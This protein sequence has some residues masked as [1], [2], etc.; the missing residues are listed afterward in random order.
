M[1]GFDT[2]G[3]INSEFLKRMERESRLNE[4]AREHGWRKTISSNPNV[5]AAFLTP[6]PNGRS[7]EINWDDDA[8]WEAAFAADAE[9]YRTEAA[10]NWQAA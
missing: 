6:G 3:P 10:K 4:R 2:R 7:I 8:A 5:Y 9:R 1:I